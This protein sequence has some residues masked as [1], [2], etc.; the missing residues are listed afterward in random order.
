M[1]SIGRLVH[2]SQTSLFWCLQSLPVAKKEAIYTLYAFCQ[3]ID[4]VVD[5]KI[6]ENLLNAWEVELFN[7]YER[8]VPATDIGRRIYKNCMRFKIKKEDFSEILN[9]ALLD[10]PT[11]LCCPD[12]GTFEKYCYGS[13]VIPIYITLVIMGLWNEE[14]MRRLSLSLGRAVFITNVLKNVKEDAL[15]G[16]IYMPKELLHQAGITSTDPLN[17]ITDP[18]L[19]NVRENLAEIAFKDFE[20]AYIIITHKD[21]KE[22][23][24]LRLILNTYKRYYDI[25]Q[26]RGWEIMSPK[27]EIKR[28][29]KIKI[30]FNI[31]FD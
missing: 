22:T 19:I 9:A 29:D 24:V 28:W 15:A 7:I 2:K 11:P 21:K 5:G 30:A 3:H 10:Y 25:M 17:I 27:P 14:I 4:N 13:M 6:K 26:H 8:K 18:N 20:E 23:R 12:A 1:S 16:H 31:L